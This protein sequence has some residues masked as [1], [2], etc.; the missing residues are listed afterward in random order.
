MRMCL[1]HESCSSHW[2]DRWT[3][4]HC[5]S[6]ISVSSLLDISWSYA[7]WLL[8]RGLHRRVNSVELLNSTFGSLVSKIQH[9]LCRSS[10]PFKRW[11]PWCVRRVWG[12]L[13]RLFEPLFFVNIIEISVCF[14]HL[15]I[16]LKIGPTLVRNIVFSPTGWSNLQILREPLS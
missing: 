1:P 7:T 10:H 8:H 14:I 2:A 13:S 4:Q 16:K 9:S 3:R 5:E 11:L 15:S 6:W 12:R